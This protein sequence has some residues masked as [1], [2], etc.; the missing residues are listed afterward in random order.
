MTPIEEEEVPLAGPVAPAAPA[1]GIP[2]ALAAAQADE[3]DDLVEL[4]EEEVPLAVMDEEDIQ[5][6]ADETEEDEEVVVVEDEEV[7][8]ANN[9]VESAKHCILHFWEWLIAAVLAGYYVINTKKEKNEIAELKG[10]RDHE[11]GKRG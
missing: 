5:E 7:P 4:E 6:P 2:V 9:L 3:E 1:A 11:D 10:K 8:L